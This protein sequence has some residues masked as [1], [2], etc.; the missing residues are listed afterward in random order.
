VLDRLAYGP[1]RAMLFLSGKR[2]KLIAVKA[3]TQGDW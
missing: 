3:A 2:Y 1:M